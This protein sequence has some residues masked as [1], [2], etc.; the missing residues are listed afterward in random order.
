[1][2]WTL[3]ELEKWRGREGLDADGES[4]GR[5]FATFVG[6]ESHAPRWIAVQT[7]THGEDVTPVP[8]EGAE[9]T[10]TAIRFPHAA[11]TIQAAPHLPAA[12]RLTPEQDQ[13]LE[14]FYGLHTAAPRAQ[15]NPPGPGP[16]A[17]PGVVEALRAAHAL[18]HEALSRLQ[19]LQSALEDSELQHD[20]A[21][22][23]T[24]TEGHEAAIA[25]RLEQLE[26]SPPVVREL[27]AIA[28]PALPSGTAELLRDAL[29]F[30]R[31]ECSAY[32]DLIAAARGAGDDASRE[33]AV[34]IHADEE[35]MAETVAAA[36]R[37]M[38]EQ[39]G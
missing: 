8:V 1:M 27:L 22:H 28:K 3:E 21:R 38:G 9:P 2:R 18:E 17:D 11:G 4:V 31:R 35:A 25:G 36:L 37:R 23:L 26:A 19:S 13:E 10:G 33:I 6:E 16:G 24:E 20:V 30:E 15:P 39:P 29:E 14:E 32:D 7:G 12:G 5:V 34:R